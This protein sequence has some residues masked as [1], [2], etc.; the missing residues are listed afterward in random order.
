[1]IAVDEDRPRRAGSGKLT[2]YRLAS[3]LGRYSQYVMRNHVGLHRHF[4]FINL[5]VGGRD[6]IV[7]LRGPKDRGI[8]L[9]A[10][11]R[12]LVDSVEW[13]IFDDLLIGTS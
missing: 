9:E 11:R 12:S 3:F 8:T 4:A 13:G 6:H 7:D 2:R 5:R 1:M 10:P